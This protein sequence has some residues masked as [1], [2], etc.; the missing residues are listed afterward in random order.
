[1]IFGSF[2]VY[3]EAPDNTIGDRIVLDTARAL[4]HYPECVPGSMRAYWHEISDLKSLIYMPAMPC[5]EGVYYYMYRSTVNLPKD[6]GACINFFALDSGVAYLEPKF[7]Q[8]HDA[9]ASFGH[10]ARVQ[11]PARS[12]GLRETAGCP[13]ARTHPSKS[14]RAFSQN[15]EF[16]SCMHGF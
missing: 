13:R 10:R 3:F 8:E 1:M 9:R 15:S 11:E 16:R 14:A 12:R 5:E 6:G 7:A 4:A 2:N